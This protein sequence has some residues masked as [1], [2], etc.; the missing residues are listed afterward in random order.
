M[1]IT[2]FALLRSQ[3]AARCQELEPT[4]GERQATLPQQV[5]RRERRRT[6]QCNIDFG[7]EQTEVPSSP[8]VR[9]HERCL[10]QVEFS[11]DGAH[12]GVSQRRPTRQKGNRPGFPVKASVVNASTIAA[13]TLSALGAPYRSEA[14]AGT[15]R[16]TRAASGAERRSWELPSLRLGGL[17]EQFKVATPTQSPAAFDVVRPLPAGGS[18]HAR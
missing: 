17:A 8:G 11:C 9:C 15:L 18:R 3:R 1:P 4:A 6:T 12:P 14:I 5:R 2:C 16:G 7:G 10:G 13:A